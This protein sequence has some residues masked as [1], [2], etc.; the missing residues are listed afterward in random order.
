MGLFNRDTNDDE[1]NE[2]TTKDPEPET[3]FVEETREKEYTEHTATVEFVDGT[4]REFVFDAIA[5]GNGAYTLKNYTGTYTE[6][7]AY[8]GPEERF[9]SEAFASIPK[10]NVKVFETTD[11]VDETMEYT[12]EVK[13]EVAGDE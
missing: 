6:K 1:P 13:Q 4:E 7:L 3:K 5:E 11:R 12:V 9:T 10:R 8:G 2:T